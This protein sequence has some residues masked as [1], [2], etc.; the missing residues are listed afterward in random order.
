M[1]RIV[2]CL[3]MANVLLLNV[4]GAHAQTYPNK[5][6]RIVTGSVG[7]NSDF[8]SRF[9]A[10][11]ISPLL[12]QPVIVENRGGGIL[13][14][15]TV[16]K[17]PPDGY[18]VLVA[19]GT[20]WNGPLLRP[21]PFDAVSD[22]APIS[23]MNRSPLLFVVHPTLPV[24]SVKEFIALAKARPGQLNSSS[25]SIG[26]ASHLA[27]ELFRQMSGINV[28]RVNYKS[29]GTEMTDL[30]AGYIQYTI[31]TTGEV[32]PHVQSG[33]L[34]ALA[35]TGPKPSPL[36]PGLPT[37]ASAGLEGYE[38]LSM[39]GMFA[40]AKTPPAIVN[41]LSQEIARFVKTPEAQKKFLESGVEAVGSTPEEL[42]TAMN[43]EIA[44]WGKLI[45]EVGIKAD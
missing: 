7:G 33:K 4:N 21:T 42:A 28:V 45:K 32:G 18:T 26:S 34:K 13:P 25:S 43:A 36:L 30:V 6:V 16:V 27:G 17:S 39:T 31:G 3:A 14:G 40:P 9:V 35:V 11:G 38:A 1:P 24:K 5:P 20:L 23:L 8:S 10:Q 19:A 15:L 22:F 41:R 2:M 29:G 37:V 44:R 12:G